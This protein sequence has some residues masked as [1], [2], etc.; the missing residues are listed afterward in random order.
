MKTPSVVDNNGYVWETSRANEGQFY[1]VQASTT[2]RLHVDIFPFYP[3]NGFMT[4]DTWM[5]HR[6]DKKFPESFLKPLTKVPFVGMWVSAPNNIRDFLE[7]KFGAGCIEHP[8]YPNPA[9]IAYP[10]NFLP[11][12]LKPSDND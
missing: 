2:N 3:K 11:T 1:R 9:L 4:K 8:E 6:Q 10:R 7:F 12:A 5:A